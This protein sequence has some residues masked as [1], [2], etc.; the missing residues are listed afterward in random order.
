MGWSCKVDTT[1]S[2][3]TT[4]TG[5][6]FDPA[7]QTPLANVVVF[8]PEDATQ[9]PPIL[10]GTSTCDMCSRSIGTYVA[11][12]ITDSAGTFT[13]KGVPTGVNVP[14]V[15]QLGKWRRTVQVNIAKDCQ[16]NTVSMSPSAPLLRLPATK[17]EGDMPQI[18]LLT[19]GCDDM[20]CLLTRFGIKPSEFGAP[21]SG[22]RVDV[23]Q[24]LGAAGSGPGLSYGSAGDCTGAACPLWST[25]QDLEYY[26][27]VLLG[28]EC[29][30]HNETK[31]PAAIQAMHDWLG[32][33]GR[34][35][36]THYQ[37]TWFKN[38]PS[39]FQ[40][41]AGWLPSQTDGPTP[42]PFAIDSSWVPG[43]N[44]QTWL[45]FLG[46]LNPDRTLPLNAAH[47]SASVSSVN[48][49]SSRWIYDSSSA[50]AGA[51]D[52][53]KFLSFLTPVGGIPDD[54]GG[55]SYCGQAMFTDIHPGGAGLASGA[56]V[57]ASCTGGSSSA[58][59]KALEYLFFEM[60]SSC[61]LL[62]VKG[63]PPQAGDAATEG[64]DATTDADVVDAAAEVSTD[65]AGQ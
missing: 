55:L 17:S 59:E 51:A 9:L 57:P 49:A 29:G 61:A 21:H 8:V 63:G 34:V 36:A 35:W 39:D 46:A 27:L 6:V 10:R 62:P 53:T 28:C 31:P 18:A 52:G 64:D 41:V 19:G 24:G 60:S 47:I 37:S 56:S 65:A 15:V 44:L 54:G 23:Y 45:N 42:G 20:A 5:K 26:D 7:G 1:C 22:A 38:G 40:G 2:T 58:E 33:G 50:G 16:I 14:V 32:E 48:A 30:E 43:Q 13:L 11:V 25:R 12:T 3:P 4:L